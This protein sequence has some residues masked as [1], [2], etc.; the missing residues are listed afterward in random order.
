MVPRSDPAGTRTQDHLIKSQ[1][2]YQLS[3]RISANLASL[4]VSITL[5]IMSRQPRDEIARLWFPVYSFTLYH[6]VSSSQSNP[7]ETAP[8]LLPGSTDVPSGNTGCFLF[9]S[10]DVLAA[11]IVF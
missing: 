5:P 6:P 4:S 11:I 7:A 8:T 9:V 2:L 3:Y 1:V 10:P